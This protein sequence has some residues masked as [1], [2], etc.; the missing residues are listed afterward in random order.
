MWAD[1]LELVIAGEINEIG[2]R[3]SNVVLIGEGRRRRR[4]RMEPLSVR[5]P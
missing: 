5:T 4:L 1:Y 2:E 3:E